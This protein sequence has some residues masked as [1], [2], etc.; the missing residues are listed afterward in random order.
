[1]DSTLALNG[2][3]GN[4]AI[5]GGLRLYQSCQSTDA[6]SR[7]DALWWGASSIGK[8]GIYTRSTVFGDWSISQLID[9]PENRLWA[10]SLS[11]SY[12]MECLC[13]DIN[14]Q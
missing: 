1:M 12:T 9:G 7:M 6:L 4:P 13:T 14:T 11:C 2:P 3:R 5:A 10:E 8:I